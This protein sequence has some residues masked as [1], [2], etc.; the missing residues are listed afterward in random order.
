V[1][2]ELRPPTLNQHALDAAHVREQKM[3]ERGDLRAGLPNTP[4]VYRQTGVRL[5]EAEIDAALAWTRGG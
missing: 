3:V 5:A 1:V 2:A 4:E